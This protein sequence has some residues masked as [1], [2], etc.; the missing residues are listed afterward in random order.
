M[1][2]SAMVP[3]PTRLVS[4]I[5][6]LGGGAVAAGTLKSGVVSRAEGMSAV[7]PTGVFALT[8]GIAP[9]G[10]MERGGS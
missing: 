9:R 5:A 7:A 10:A 1:V 3:V 6:K 2:V 8:S 4:V